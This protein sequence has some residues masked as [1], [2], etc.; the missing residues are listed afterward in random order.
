MY[1]HQEQNKYTNNNLNG[2]FTKEPGTGYRNV[3]WHVREAL[4]LQYNQPHYI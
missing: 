2:L 4:Y 3:N 1:V